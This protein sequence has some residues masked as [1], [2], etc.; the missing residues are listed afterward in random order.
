MLGSSYI[1]SLWG[2]VCC[3]VLCCVVFL[4]PDELDVEGQKFGEPDQIQNEA[5]AV[6]A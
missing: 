6:E 4:L 2:C 1:S 3:V 5:Q